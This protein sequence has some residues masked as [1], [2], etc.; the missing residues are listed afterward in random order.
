ATFP[1]HTFYRKVF[2]LYNSAPGAASVLS[3]SFVPGDLGCLGP[4]VSLLPAGVFCVM[5]F[6]AN[7]GS[8]SQDALTAGR[9]DWNPAKADRI[10]WRFQNDSG[11][12]KLLNPINAVF[13]TA[14]QQRWWQ[15]QAAEIHT[16]NVSA[17]NQLFFAYGHINFSTGVADLAK[18]MA[19]L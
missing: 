2:D 9:M 13:D 5:H 7:V 3:G 8:P 6:L 10:F 19:A 17:A 12:T 18:A 11:Y 4:L 16:L 1:S 15:I 14:I